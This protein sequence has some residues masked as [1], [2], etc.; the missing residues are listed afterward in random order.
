MLWKVKLDSLEKVVE[1]EDPAD[2]IRIARQDVVADVAQQTAVPLNDDERIAYEAEQAEIIAQAQ[3][4]A[5]ELGEPKLKHNKH[6]K[7]K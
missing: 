7:H 6:N 2:A 1:S 5:D 4:K 3:G